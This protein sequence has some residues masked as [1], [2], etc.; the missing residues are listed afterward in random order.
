MG[1]RAYKLNTSKK[2]SQTIVI[3]VF[4]HLRKMNELNKF[5]ISGSSDPDTSSSSRQDM[6][7][8]ARTKLVAKLKLLI[9]IAL[10]LITIAIIVFFYSNKP[11]TERRKNNLTPALTVSVHDIVSQD[12]RVNVKSY[13]N[14][15]PRTQTSLFSQV[16]GQ[17]VF[18]SDN[19]RE[20]SFFS[21]GEVL[22]KTDDRDSRSDVK[23]A[24]AN[25]ADAEQTLSE[26]LAQASQ[27]ELDW[28]RLGN[29][30]PPSDLVLRKPQQQAA[31]ARL[32]SAE[33]GLVK[34]QLSLE[35][36]EV[37][38]PYSGRVLS[39]LVD[40]GQ[41]VN[42][43]TR[44]AEIYA[45]DYLEIRL[46]I[47]SSDLRFVD[48]PETYRGTDRA[49]SQIPV[50]IYSSLSGETEP[51]AGQI[52]RTESAID[53]SARQLHVVAQVDDPFGPAASDR[54]QLKIGEYVTADIQ[55]KT[56]ANSIVVPS[57]AIYQ[58]SYAYVVKDGLIL[59]RDIK[60][61]WKNQTQSLIGSGLAQGD[62]LVTT[63]LGQISSGMKVIVEGEKPKPRK[64][65]PHQAGAKGPGARADKIP[66]KQ[67]TTR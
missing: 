36:T 13:G 15:A 59:R 62:R 38:A 49:A 47:R 31:R 18:I 30:E 35:R 2:M 48:L 17:V 7:A 55:G 20:G 45:T 16:N 5:E 26:E 64:H 23:I 3:G 66:M 39:K 40:L 41:L 63:T 67:E 12:F 25:L 14:I 61:L 24:Q 33:A 32:A 54:T 11:T 10:I 53:E 29:T 43:T 1:R 6:S 42:G 4:Q 46:P 28:K 22:L 9:P 27:A 44:V 8:S 60:V 65:G 57:Q 51:W 56:V 34:A 52:V 37:I 19:L 58:D 50:N 21:K